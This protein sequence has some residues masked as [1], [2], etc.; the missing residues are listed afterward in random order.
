MRTSVTVRTDW[1]T[2]TAIGLSLVYLV[3]FAISGGKQAFLGVMVF[4]VLPWLFLM[5]PEELGSWSYGIPIGYNPGVNRATPGSFVYI[6]G[7]IFLLAPAIYY[8]IVF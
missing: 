7:W 6:L 2:A 4:L 1:P 5:Y 8:F 3:F